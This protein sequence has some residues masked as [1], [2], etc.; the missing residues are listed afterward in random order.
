MVEIAIDT[1]K[2]LVLMVNPGLKAHQT[3]CV[4]VSGSLDI[5]SKSNLV[6]N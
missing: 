3:P 6:F 4:W 5:S 1:M 2:F